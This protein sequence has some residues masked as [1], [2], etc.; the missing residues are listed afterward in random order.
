MGNLPGLPYPGSSRG[1][2]A[3][4]K[5]LGVVRYADDFVLTHANKEILEKC[6]KQTE[7]WLSTMGLEISTEKSFIRD[8]RGGFN[9]LGFQIIQVRKKAKKVYKTKIIPSKAKQLQFCRHI[10]E[11]IQKRKASSTYDLVTTLRPVVIGWA[12]YYRFSECSKVFGTLTH[13]IFLKLRAWAFRRSRKNRK[14]WK[15]KFFPTGRTYSF[16]GTLHQDNWILVGK[17]LGKDGKVVENFLPHIVWI[18][19]EKFVKVK[20]KESLF[21][22][23]LYW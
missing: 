17:K 23:S 6:V 5:A 9:F 20:A 11:I 1:R 14:Y 15:E 18:P 12:N 3:R 13:K 10:R 21:N 7:D 22:N 2:A 8:C 16:K 19:S 4:T